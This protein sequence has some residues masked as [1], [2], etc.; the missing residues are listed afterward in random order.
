MAHGR[1]GKDWNYLS[2][3]K[4]FLKINLNEKRQ[5]VIPEELLFVSLK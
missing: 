5:Q 1:T 4:D 3:K 2:S